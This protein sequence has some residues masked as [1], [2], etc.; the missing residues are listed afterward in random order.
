MP[1]ILDK[2]SMLQTLDKNS[3]KILN[4]AADR[5]KP[6]NREAFIEKMY[7]YSD[8]IAQIESG[9]NLQAYNI[10][11]EGKEQSSAKGLYQFTDDSYKTAKRRFKNILGTDAPEGGIIDLDKEQQ[12]ALFFAN[13]L[14]VP[15]SDSIISKF[16]NQDNPMAERELYYKKHYAGKVDTA[17]RKNVER[18]IPLSNMYF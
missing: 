3:L 1:G 12:T 8:K 13:L 16:M 11:Q 6:A 18:N 7:K 2:N 9:G 4:L 14:E 10:P 17:T 15:G 5:L